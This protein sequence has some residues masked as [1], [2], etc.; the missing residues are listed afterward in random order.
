MP[1]TELKTEI[2]FCKHTQTNVFNLGYYFNH[3]GHIDLKK[4][5][6]AAEYLRELYGFKGN[7]FLHEIQKSS[8]RKYN[9]LIYFDDEKQKKVDKAFEVDS[10]WGYIG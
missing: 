7:A 4:N 2:Y 5:Y 3:S 10:F 1:I 9:I 8:T 6:E